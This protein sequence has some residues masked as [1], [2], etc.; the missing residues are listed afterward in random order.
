V[1]QRA[2]AEWITVGADQHPA[3]HPYA[4]HQRPDVFVIR[5]QRDLRGV[6]TSRPR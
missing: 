4:L 6:E 3:R 1:Y 2:A 5:S